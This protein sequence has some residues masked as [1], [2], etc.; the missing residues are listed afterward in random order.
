M[1][2]TAIGTIGIIVLFALLAL[3]MPVAMT[4]LVVGFVGAIAINGLTA[5]LF[6]AV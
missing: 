6:F 1:S 3:R 2:E 4:M 5:A